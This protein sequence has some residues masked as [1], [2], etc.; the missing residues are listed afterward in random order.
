[1]DEN[2][3]IWFVGRGLDI[4]DEFLRRTL[5]RAVLVVHYV[6]WAMVNKDRATNTTRECM[7]ERHFVGPAELVK[8]HRL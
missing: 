6:L 7:D 8:S 2:L 5:T 4:E 3:L 1:M